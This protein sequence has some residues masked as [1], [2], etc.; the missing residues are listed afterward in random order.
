MCLLFTPKMC[1]KGDL[2]LSLFLST[3]YLYYLTR[4]STLIPRLPFTPLELV[5]LRALQ[6]FLFF[7]LVL[8]HF[9][10]FD[11]YLYLRQQVHTVYLQG[12]C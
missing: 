2:R 6:F 7:L 10:L 12:P 9:R 1:Y 5:V 11:R 4:N 8:I 3:V